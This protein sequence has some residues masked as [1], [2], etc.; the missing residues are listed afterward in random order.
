VSRATTERPLAGR[1]IAITRP[2]AQ[3]LDF[4][5]RLEAAGASV[6]VV[7]T[8]AV[9]PPASWAPLDR[10]LRALASFDWVVFTSVNGVAATRRRMARLGVPLSR[11][12]A[13]RLAAIG[14]AT[15][16]AL[17][18][19]GAE[20]ELVPT[21]YVAEALL[22][23]L[24][25]RLRPG[26][27]VLLPRAAETRDVLARG[28]AALGTEVVEVPAYRTR[29]ARAGAAPLRRALAAGR[30]DAVTFTSA[31]TV[32]H[33]AALF[34][35]G[36][37]ARLMA[38]VTVACIGPVTRAAAA[39]AGLGAGVVAEEYT[40]AGLTRALAAHFASRPPKEES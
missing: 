12:R 18:R 39:A 20:P 28:L 33:F 23:A 1:L 13:R 5:R 10:A 22:D 9:G 14:P 2:R 21:R 27:R 19:L 40:V 11:L 15:A 32:R 31:S 35:P 34:A 26:A 6:L 4:R 17:R 29:A 30:V 24:R 37:R 8:I 38:G 25:D 3:A 36:E 7:P 16:A